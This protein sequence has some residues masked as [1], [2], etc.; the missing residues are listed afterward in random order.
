MLYFAYGSNLNWNQIK[1][2]CPSAEFFTAAKLKD[3]RLAFTRKS[4]RRGGG[5]ADAVPEPG[6]NVWG[7]VYQMD[8]NEITALDEAEDYVPGRAQ[9]SYTR[10]QCYVYA[11]G[12]EEKPIL[13]WLY[14]AEKQENPPLPS[15]AYKQLIVE[16]AK[17]WRLPQEYIQE[18]EQIKVAR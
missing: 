18:L 15:A 10:Q 17:H 8:E 1:G 4:E 11:D 5:S 3:Y 7:I 6:C 16:G 12:N 9:N 14:F 2:R 13:V